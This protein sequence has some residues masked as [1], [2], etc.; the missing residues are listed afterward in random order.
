VGSCAH[1]STRPVWAGTAERRT[2]PCGW[3]MAAGRQRTRYCPQPQP[4]E[5][6]IGAD[7]RPTR[8]RRCGHDGMD[9]CVGYD[10]VRYTVSPRLP[11]R[12]GNMPRGLRSSSTHEPDSAS[13]VTSS[14]SASE[15]PCVCVRVRVCDVC[16]SVCACV[17]AQPTEPRTRAGIVTRGGRSAAPRHG[18]AVV[19][20]Y[21]QAV[22]R[23]RGGQCACSQCDCSRLRRSKHR[24]AVRARLRSLY[25]CR[26]QTTADAR[27][28]PRGAASCIR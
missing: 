14:L 13:I 28:G 4:S 25:G 2:V 22:C 9:G 18:Y 26:R 23:K 19:P 11:R 27:H 21:R 20:E 24:S 5:L 1:V 16:A 3:R 10:G 8:P 15:K 6:Y 7:P 17:Y 12:A